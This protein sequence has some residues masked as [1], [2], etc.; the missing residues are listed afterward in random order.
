MGGSNSIVSFLSGSI[1]D[2][3]GSIDYVIVTNVENRE[4]I[5]TSAKRSMVESVSFVIWPSSLVKN[6]GSIVISFKI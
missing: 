4:R 3:F 6:G 1:E 2:I 5:R